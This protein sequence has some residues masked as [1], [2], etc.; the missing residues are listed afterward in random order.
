MFGIER[1][2]QAEDLTERQTALLRILKDRLTGRSTGETRPFLYNPSTGRLAES[3]EANP[4]E[5]TKEF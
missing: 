3:T 1:D 4:F 5:E 2:Q